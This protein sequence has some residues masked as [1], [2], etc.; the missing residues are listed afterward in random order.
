MLMN[1]SLELVVNPSPSIAL[2]WFCTWL[3]ISSLTLTVSGAQG[4]LSSTTALS[5]LAN[6]S[7]GRTLKYLHVYNPNASGVSLTI[8]V[9]AGGVLTTI[10]NHYLD[11]GAYVEYVDCDGSLQCTSDGALKYVL[12]T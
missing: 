11:A 3:D 7:E 5:I 1:S 8:Q 9:N 2:T 10:S 6:R 4:T 12:Q